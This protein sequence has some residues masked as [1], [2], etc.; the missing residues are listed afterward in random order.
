[1]SG[2]HNGMKMHFQ[3]STAHFNCIHCF[4]HQ[5][6]QFDKFKNF[7][8]LLL[9]LHHLLKNFKIQSAYGLD[10][11]KFIKAAATC[12]LS[13]GTTAQKVLDRFEP[14]VASLDAMYL[15]KYEPAVRGLHDSL[16]QPNI[17]TLCFLTD[18]L[19]S[20]NVLQMILQG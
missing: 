14:L 12:W 16:N 8:S 5:I 11:L 7:D 1:M 9:N 6:S 17:S 18:V 13:H 15:C 2:E 20:T 10:S 19:K 4:V 3:N